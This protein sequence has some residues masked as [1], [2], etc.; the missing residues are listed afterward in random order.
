MK[1]Q[2]LSRPT[3]DVNP[4]TVDSLENPFP[5]EE[6]IRETAPIV[7][8]SDLNVWATGRYDLVQSIFLDHA[9]F[10]SSHGT[11]LTNTAREKNWRKP[12]VIL[13]QDPPSHTKTRKVMSSVL[14]L[15]VVKQLKDEFQQAAYDMV[16]RL[17]ELREFD[18]VADLA[19]AY[20]LQVLPDA[21]GLAPEGREHLLKYANLNFQAMGPR[22]ALYEQA[23]AEAAQ[24]KEY[25]EWQMDRQNL[26]E[27]KLA[28]K[29]FAAADDGTIT[30]EQGSLLVRTF[31]SAGL[32]TTMLGIGLALKA[33]AETP[34][35]W[36]LLSQNSKLARTVFE[37]TLRAYAPSP[38]IG[39]T[40]GKPVEIGGVVLQPEEK[41]IN[42]VSAANRDPRHWERPTEFDIERDVRGHA[43]FG[44]GIH[45]CVGQMMARMEAESVLTAVAEKVHSIELTG[46]PTRKI[47]HWLRGYERMPVRIIPK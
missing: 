16:D 17:C 3:I 8:L 23:V 27:S 22:N 43:A 31:L 47:N 11:G 36:N 24:A 28:G 9:T 14:S 35:A 26:D 19:E 42:C 18:A 12:S 15:K 21:V 13:E 10:I 41:I 4:F 1:T 37:E 25:V 2:N 38:F 6:Q 30:Q 45:A 46:E 44:Y 34:R 40:V 7:W 29:I 33:L 32:D 39:R 5:I 20:P